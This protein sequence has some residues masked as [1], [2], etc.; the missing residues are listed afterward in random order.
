MRTSS[1]S[2]LPEVT[3]WPAMI[4]WMVIIAVIVG[5]VVRKIK[6]KKK[7]PVTIPPPSGRRTAGTATM[8]KSPYSKPKPRA[9]KAPLLMGKIRQAKRAVGKQSPKV[10]KKKD[11]MYYLRCKQCHL[12]EFL[13]N[14]ADGQQYCTKCGWKKR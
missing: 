6:R 1:Q 11:V 14:E 10:K 9:G 8:T 4:F 7:I 2:Q 13:E 12:E 3:N 5:V